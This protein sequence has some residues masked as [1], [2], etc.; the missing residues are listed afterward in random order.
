MNWRYQDS[1]APGR[2]NKTCYVGKETNVSRLTVSLFITELSQ[3]AVM[4][5]REWIM[6]VTCDAY[7]DICLVMAN[8][9]LSHWLAIEFCV[10]KT[11]HFY[12][13]CINVNVHNWRLFID[14]SEGSIDLRG[15]IIN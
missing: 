10:G 1:P 12:E 3:N 13:F 6:W 4:A 8:Y 11:S 9:H 5:K 15:E 14:V 2:P 7:M